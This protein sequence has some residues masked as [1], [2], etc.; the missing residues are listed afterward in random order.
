MEELNVVRGLLVRTICWE[1]ANGKKDGESEREKKKKN[2]S[3]SLRLCLHDASLDVVRGSM[4]VETRFS[5]RHHS[6][7]FIV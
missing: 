2:N 3:T 5:V 7:I 6:K 1:L 4:H